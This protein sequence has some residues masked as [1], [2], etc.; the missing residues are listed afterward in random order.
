[1]TMW[2]FL[3]AHFEGIVVTFLIALFLIGVYKLISKEL[4]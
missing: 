4:L 2:D 1:M 3:H